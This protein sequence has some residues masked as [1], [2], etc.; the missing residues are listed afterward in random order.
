MDQDTTWHVYVGLGPA[1]V[2][3]DYGFNDLWGQGPLSKLRRPGPKT[4]S[5]MT[6]ATDTVMSC[7]R[8]CRKQALSRVKYYYY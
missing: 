3:L 2:V 8:V 4:T 6:N 1:N 5:K 7:M